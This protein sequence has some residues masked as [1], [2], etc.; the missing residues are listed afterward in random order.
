M[1]ENMKDYYVSKIEDTVHELTGLL[2]RMRDDAAIDSRLVKLDLRLVAY[3][4]GVLV[5]LNI[6]G[7]PNLPQ[8]GQLERELG[9]VEGSDSPN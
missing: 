3:G 1:D 4:R 8:V 6:D 7:C 2:K 5:S 9:L